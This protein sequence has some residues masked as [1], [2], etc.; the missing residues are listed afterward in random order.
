MPMWAYKGVDPRG[1]QVTAVRAAD[2]PKGV[3]ATMRREGILVTD[4]SEAR[5]GKTTTASTGSGLRREVDLRGIFQ[6]VKVPEVAGFTRQLA[7]LLK[8]GIPLAESLGA[9]VDQI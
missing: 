8:A 1:K 3:G 2:S 5:A 7:T 6:T 4:V 9:L